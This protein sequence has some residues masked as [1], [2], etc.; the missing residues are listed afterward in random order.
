MSVSPARGTLLCLL[1]GGAA[2]DEGRSSIGWRT[3]APSVRRMSI[4]SKPMNR[5]LIAHR[6]EEAA[7]PIESSDDGIAEIAARVGYETAS[8]FSKLFRRYHGASP[9]RFRP[10]AERRAIAIV[11]PVAGRRALGAA[12]NC[13]SS[14]FWPGL[15]SAIPRRRRSKVTRSAAATV[16]RGRCEV[17]REPALS[18]TR[19]CTL[20][21]APRRTFS[22][23]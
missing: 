21:W 1:P 13:G 18:P 12:D 2:R 10:H 15:P 9:G 14:A 5:Y 6:M 17:F 16:R 20:A 22:R 4:A 3:K 23:L 7:S 11:E 19:K 8:A